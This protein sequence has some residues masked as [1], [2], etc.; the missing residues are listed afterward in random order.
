MTKI[1]QK[2]FLFLA[3][4]FLFFGLAKNVEAACTWNGNIGTPASTSVEDCQS[5][6]DQIVSAGK[7]GEIKSLVF[8]IFRV[9]VFSASALLLLLLCIVLLWV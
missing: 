5:C 4:L 6:V 3:F 1:F 2:L 9:V 7:T 8:F